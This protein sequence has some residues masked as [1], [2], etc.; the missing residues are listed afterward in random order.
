MIGYVVKK[1][2]WNRQTE[3]RLFS[4][5]HFALM[6]FRKRIHPSAFE[7]QHVTQFCQQSTSER[8]YSEF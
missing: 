2:K 7:T 6:S 1:K 4:C 5:Y 8:D 3:F